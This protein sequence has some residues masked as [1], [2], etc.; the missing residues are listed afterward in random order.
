MTLGDTPPFAVEAKAEK[1]AMLAEVRLT[2]SVL[3]AVRDGVA[4]SVERQLA[5]SGRVETVVM[6]ED[7]MRLGGIAFAVEVVQAALRVGSG[8]TMPEDQALEAAG[9]LVAS[10]VQALSGPTLERTDGH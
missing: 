2:A 8:Y 10:G 4:L 3:R 1:E 7:A 6:L 5:A 9:A